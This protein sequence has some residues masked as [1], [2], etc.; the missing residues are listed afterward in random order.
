MLL[1][2]EVFFVILMYDNTGSF[3]EEALEERKQG[4]GTL[5]HRHN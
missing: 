2:Q 3:F 1:T 4:K 5:W